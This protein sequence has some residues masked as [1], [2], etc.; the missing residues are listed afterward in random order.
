MWLND[1]PQTKVLTSGVPL[2][3][4]G[5]ASFQIYATVLSIFCVYPNFSTAS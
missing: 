2:F 3:E 4:P 5:T 1:F